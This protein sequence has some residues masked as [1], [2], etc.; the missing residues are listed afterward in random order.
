LVSE[1]SGLS[2]LEHSSLDSVSSFIFYRAYGSK[3]LEVFSFALWPLYLLVS[4][5]SVLAVS[6]S[7]VN[8]CFLESEF[9]PKIFGSCV[10]L[11]EKFGRSNFVGRS[12]GMFRLRTE[13]SAGVGKTWE[14]AHEAEGA[15]IGSI[16]WDAVSTQVA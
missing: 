16:F 15:E 14:R 1:I 5:S 13:G 11:F 4:L 12:V 3:V 10:L 9:L 8:S 7:T 2:W 6:V